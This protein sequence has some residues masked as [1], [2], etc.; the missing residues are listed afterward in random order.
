MVEI[1][2]GILHDECK[3]LFEDP[4]INKT[5]KRRFAHATGSKLR[6]L[7]TDVFGESGEHKF[8]PPPPATHGTHEEFM[9]AAIRCVQ[10]GVRDG[11]NKEREPFG[12]VIVKDGKVISESVS[13]AVTERDATA[14]AE[15][16]AIRR[17]SKHLG[18]HNLEG[19]EMYCTAHP[20][21]MSLGAVLWARISRVYCGL[22]QNEAAV[23][24]FEEGIL[25]F[26]DLVESGK[27]V[28]EVIEGV[29]KD[30]C[31]N[32]F[33]EWSNLNGVLY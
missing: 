19:C 11:I 14:T 4:Q 21:L 32:V 9:R 12:A 18:T 33:K 5:L 13:T 23:G 15:V 2:D 28:T 16:N 31:E 1:Y 26:R 8:R 29:A 6:K 17:A 7:H 3:Q 25:H 24:G 10:L 20:D 27:R 22:T 30:E